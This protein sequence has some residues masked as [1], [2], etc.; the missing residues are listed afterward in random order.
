MLEDI[1]FC[2]LSRFDAVD[3]RETPDGVSIFIQKVASITLFASSGV[4]TQ[5]HFSFGMKSPAAKQLG[6]VLSSR[7]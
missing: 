6:R 4:P 1:C 2:V 3:N 5:R 7:G